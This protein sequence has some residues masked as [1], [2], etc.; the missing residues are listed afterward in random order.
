MRTFVFYDSYGKITKVHNGNNDWS[1]T[2]RQEGESVL[3]V[4][5]SVEPEDWYVASERL[6]PTV[7]FPDVSVTESP[8]INSTITV[9]NLPDDTEV[10]WPD[11]VRTRESGSF[12]FSTDVGDTFNFV[13]YHAHHPM[14]R[15]SIDVAS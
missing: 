1:E 14:K 4:F 10:M 7:P 13:L 5:E 2:N 15:L 12:T 3:E 6:L 9:S 11:E 8:T